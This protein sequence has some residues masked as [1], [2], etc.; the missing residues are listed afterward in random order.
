MFLKLDMD[1][2]ISLFLVIP[3]TCY[4]CGYYFSSLLTSTCLQNSGI[5][6]VKYHFSTLACIFEGGAA[7]EVYPSFQ[8]TTCFSVL[9][10]S[11]H[12]DHCKLSTS[13]HIPCGCSRSTGVVSLWIAVCRVAY[14]SLI[15]PVFLKM[16]SHYCWEATYNTIC[17]HF[18]HFRFKKNQQLSTTSHIT[19]CIGHIPYNIIFCNKMYVVLSS[20]KVASILS[21]QLQWTK[22]STHV[23]LLWRCFKGW[24]H[25]A[26]VINIYVYCIYIFVCMC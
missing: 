7:A 1:R 2:F 23:A 25:V 3:F 6:P 5:T 15:F 14:D 4:C 13:W 19:C 26:S 17:L 21:G 8:K 20:S 16:L 24:Q 9:W 12:V 10:H 22:F 11:V 18:H